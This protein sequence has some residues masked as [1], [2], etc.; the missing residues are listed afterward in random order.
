MNSI[1]FHI[2]GAWYWWISRKLQWASAYRSYVRDKGFHQLLNFWMSP[3]QLN[4]QKSIRK[5]KLVG[6]YFI[7]KLNEEYRSLHEG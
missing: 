1:N 5:A 6:F 7:S 4:F 2:R 3:N